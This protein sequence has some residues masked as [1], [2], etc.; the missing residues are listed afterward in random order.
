MRKNNPD[1]TSTVITE[2]KPR[3]AFEPFHARKQRFAALVCHRRAGKTVASVNDLQDAAVRCKHERPRFGYVA[4][5]LKQAKG[6]AW[7]HLRAAASSFGPDGHTVNEAELR[8]DYH[9]NNSRLQLYGADNPDAM[10]GLGFD[11]V[12]LD[13]YADFDPR[14][15]PEIVRPTLSSRKGWA[16]F[17]G[18]PRGHNAF[19]EIV[20]DA[21]NNP[22]EWFSLT[23]KASESGI[24]TEDE[25]E[26]IKLTQT[27]DQ[28]QQEYECSFEAAIHGAYYAH[29]ITRAKE[30]GRIMGV[31]YDP[32]ALVWTAWDLGIEDAT[33]IWFAQVIGRE[34]HLIDYYE[35]RGMDLGAY[36]A[37]LRDKPYVYDTHLLPHDSQAR[38][39]G[40]GKTR[41]ETLQGLGLN[42]TRVVPQ[43][44]VE[45]GINAVRLLL[46]KCYFDAVRC[47]RPLEALTLYRADVDK[48]YIDPVTKQPLLKGTAVHDWTSHCA[49]AMR[50]LA[51]GIDDKGISAAF[52]RKIE[53]PNLGLA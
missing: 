25:L 17:I 18:T 1:G 27:E 53:Y 2:Y 31:P 43:H 15:W 23:L 34:I 3:S 33:A 50:Y 42:N 16:A 6:V 14:V 5:F 10:R 37:V 19:Y 8:I 52:N 44:R 46:P 51:M 13:E 49:D 28:Y 35:A 39:L 30:E 38:E 45:D 47:E 29:L 48:R 9:T 41:H 40:T 12:V 11:G 4:P 21:R 22:E 7:D 26:S 24:L 36:V 32:S 20:R